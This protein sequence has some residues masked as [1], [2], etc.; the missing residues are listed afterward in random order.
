MVKN[1]PPYKNK[2][3]S[4][5]HTKQKKMAPRKR[6]K[7]LHIKRDT[8]YN[9]KRGNRHRVEKLKKSGDAEHVFS[10]IFSKDDERKTVN[11]EAGEYAG[12][13]YKLHKKPDVIC[14]ETYIPGNA[15]PKPNQF[16]SVSNEESSD[17][18]DNDED[19]TVEGILARNKT[20]RFF[21]SK[22]G[23]RM[24]YELFM[25]IQYEDPM[26]HAAKVALSKAI[27]GK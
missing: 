22:G 25:W 1:I 16:E 4:L 19:T 14:S 21:R 11:I 5:S 24:L 20:S 6:N 23:I 27:S 2:I 9:F 13:I 3:P 18:E 7:K 26:S 10:V 12:R 15:K 17:E 8:L